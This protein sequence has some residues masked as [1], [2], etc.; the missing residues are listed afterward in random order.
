MRSCDTCGIKVWRFSGW[1]VGLCQ[2]MHCIVQSSRIWRAINL[3]AFVCF[4]VCARTCAR[5]TLKC[6]IIIAVLNR[7]STCAGLSV[8]FTLATWCWWHVDW[9][10]IP[11]TNSC[12]SQCKFHHLSYALAKSVDERAVKC[13]DN[14]HTTDQKK[15][16]YRA[17][18]HEDR[19]PRLQFTT[20]IFILT[21]W[22]LAK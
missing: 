10:W 14:G 22:N 11:D 18:T 19:K 16:Y 7:L 15:R 3:M 4:V 21:K 6:I 1:D 17:S 20:I 9:L 5:C 8:V 13:T 2:R 12:A